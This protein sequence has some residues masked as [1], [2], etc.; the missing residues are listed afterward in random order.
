MELWLE[1]EKDYEDAPVGTKVAYNDGW[2]GG[3][4]KLSSGE[5]KASDGNILGTRSLR[6][7]R[8][9]V[10]YWPEEDPYAV[11]KILDGIEAYDNAPIGTQVLGSF[12]TKGFKSRDF[13]WDVE[14]KKQTGK[15]YVL[16]GAEEFPI[17]KSP[18]G[19][20]NVSHQPS[21]MASIANFRSLDTA[22]AA[23]SMLRA[24]GV[25]VKKSMIEDTD[26]L[27]AFRPIAKQL[28]DLGYVTIQESIAMPTSSGGTK[29][30]VAPQP[31]TAAY[32][33]LVATVKAEQDAAW[34]KRTAKDKKNPKA[35]TPIEE[36]LFPTGYTK[37]S[38]RGGKLLGK[39]MQEWTLKDYEKAGPL[40]PKMFEDDYR[41][42]G[43]STPRAFKTGGGLTKTQTAF[44]AQSAI[45]QLSEKD[46]AAVLS[47][48]ADKDSK[49]GTMQFGNHLKESSRESPLEFNIPGAGT[50][51]IPLGALPQFLKSLSIDPNKL[52]QLIKGV[53]FD[54]R[55]R[56]F[57]KLNLLKQILSCAK[58]D[59][60]PIDVFRAD[61]KKARNRAM[62]V[63]INRYWSEAKVDRA[64][65]QDSCRAS[66]GEC[67]R[68]HLGSAIV[69]AH[70]VAHGY[71]HHDLLVI[72]HLS[73]AEQESAR[74]NPGLAEGIRSLR[75]KFQH[76]GGLDFDDVVELLQGSMDNPW[77]QQAYG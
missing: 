6:W 51:K 34:K 14:G 69:C 33:R 7:S 27:D 12:G 54:S 1:N 49:R 32:D 50:Y 20:Y 46:L 11:G 15:G 35:A 22:K 67:L 36:E 13:A 66:C 39:P 26:S 72:G 55:S 57:V 37:V 64:L 10:T 44:V 65:R 43:Q 40:D 61:S 68:K 31:G 18:D 70:E 16:E 58:V 3:Y 8:R 71:P 24:N 60:V 25:Q 47:F 29:K 4:T 17:V 45:D 48:F 41:G 74:D 30:A 28:Q 56:Q 19:G 38:L 52:D 42:V 76:G 21:G 77:T 23:V 62:T 63:L 5:W 73:E 2:A 75:R 9:K 59:L 53:K